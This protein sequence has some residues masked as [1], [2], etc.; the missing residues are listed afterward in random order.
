MK[1][2]LF[3]N[4]NYNIDHTIDHNTETKESIHTVV[5]HNRNYSTNGYQ[6]FI[7]CYYNYN[8]HFTTPTSAMTV[9]YRYHNH[10]N[11]IFYYFTQQYINTIAPISIST[12]I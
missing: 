12:S 10:L 9:T 6:F 2:Y 7:Y 4:H 3:L 11:Y 1:I 8:N 5:T